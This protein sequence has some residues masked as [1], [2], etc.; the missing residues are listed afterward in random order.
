[1][2]PKNVRA[3]LSGT[4][5]GSLRDSKSVSFES[6]G[7]TTTAICVIIRDNEIRKHF[8]CLGFLTASSFCNSA[9]FA[10]VPSSSKEVEAVYPDA[11][12]LYLDLH[13]N[14]E[15]SAPRDADCGEVGR[16]P[17]WPRLRGDRARWRHWNCRHPQ[18]RR[19]TNGHAAHGTRRAS[20]GR[21]NWPA[22][23]QQSPR[24]RRRRTRRSRGARLRA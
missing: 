18:E 22:L 5:P 20:R 16:P 4:R 8:C 23:C 24:Q 12:A 9:A 21:K 17:A 19:G 11:H 14:P 7:S 1:M 13:Q 15:L 10:Q 2:I 3:D 6:A